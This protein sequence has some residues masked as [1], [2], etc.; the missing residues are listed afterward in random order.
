MKKD[1]GLGVKPPEK[2]CDDVKCPFHG[3]LPVRGRVFRGKVVSDKAEKTVI[4]Q[5]DYLIKK[6]KYERFERRRSKV[7]AYNPPCIS[8][9]IGDTVMIAECRP[10]SKTKK[11]VVVSILKKGTPVEKV[12]IERA[13]E[14]VEEVIEKKG[15]EKDESSTS[16]GV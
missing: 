11:F 5:W 9:S 2:V 10:L 8:A 6:P 1:I 13:Y 16:K 7:A 3:K 14:E 12:D 15:E 4:V